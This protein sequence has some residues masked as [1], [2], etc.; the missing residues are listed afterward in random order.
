[1]ISIII[2]TLNEEKIIEKTLLTLK[3]LRDFDYEIIISDGRS[4]DKTIEI[5]KKH[6]AKVIVYEGM[7]RQTISHGRNLGASIASKELLV[8][9][10]ADVEI[11]NIN[12][13]FKKTVKL[14]EE[15]K[16][17]TGL[18]TRIKIHKDV[19]T[20]ADKIILGAFDY[21][22]FF[23]NNVVGFGGA[24]GEFQM[25]RAS[26]FKELRGYNEKIAVAEDIDM[27]QRLAKKG[28]TRIEMSLKIMHPGRRAH[29]IG[30]PKLLFNWTIN[31]LTVMTKKH[32][33][34]EVWEEI[35]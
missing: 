24:S 5:A 9:L 27:F 13:F 12:N 34:H 29:K 17:L 11:P 6:G 31:G 19:E 7:T 26:A 2:P 8:F 22:N 20:L 33:Y 25:I 16:E 10:D 21:I 3:E 32:S 15:Q 18:T 30:W 23:L 4:K 35:R 1:M 28:K 14:F